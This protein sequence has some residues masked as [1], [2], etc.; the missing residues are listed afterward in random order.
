MFVASPVLHN[1]YP[2]S[3]EAGVQSGMVSEKQRTPCHV[4][5]TN[6][7]MMDFRGS[8]PTAFAT[9]DVV[10]IKVMRSYTALRSKI[11]GVGCTDF[12]L[13]ADL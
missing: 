6:L 9:Y 13:L 10:L 8:P 12:C 11:A 7:K 3:M 1:A 2:A 4:P 5:T